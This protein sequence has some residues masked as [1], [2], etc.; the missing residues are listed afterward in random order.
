MFLSTF[1]VEILHAEL[2]S[3]GS[4]SQLH[5]PAH[6]TTQTFLW[7]GFVTWVRDRLSGLVLQGSVRWALKD[8]V[9]FL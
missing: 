3:N 9:S 6:D 1:T 5:E 4:A 8:L 2:S 7:R